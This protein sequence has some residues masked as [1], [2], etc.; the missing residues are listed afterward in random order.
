LKFRTF[1]QI[2]PISGSATSQ[3][4]RKAIERRQSGALPMDC[5]L[6]QLADGG[7]SSFIERQ[8]MATFPA[9]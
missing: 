7:Q 5:S 9:D 3:E 2:D 1:K 8:W 4:H 6:E